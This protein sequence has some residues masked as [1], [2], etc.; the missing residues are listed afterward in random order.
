VSQSLSTEATAARRWQVRLH[1]ENAPI[2]LARD[3][4]YIPTV[5]EK[6]I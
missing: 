4:R 6:L 2:P 3:V 5:H 1:R